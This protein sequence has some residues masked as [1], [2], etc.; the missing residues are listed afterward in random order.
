MTAPGAYNIERVR[1]QRDIDS[2]NTHL[3]ELRRQVSEM[4]YQR[5]QLSAA[6]HM[7]FRC[8]YLITKKHDEIHA[9]EELRRRMFADLNMADY[10]CGHRRQAI[11]A[12]AHE[13]AMQLNEKSR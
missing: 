8:D 10:A 4:I 3:T 6:G 5:N 7:T 13:R 12:R 2:I 11:V 9:A 1:I